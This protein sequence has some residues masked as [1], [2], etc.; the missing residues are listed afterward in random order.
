[1]LA[2]VAAGAVASAA[3]V[4][5]VAAGAVVFAAGVLAVSEGVV[6]GAV[7]AAAAAAQCSEI[8]SSSV[9]AKLLPPAVELSPLALCPMRVTSWFRCGLR[10]TLLVATLK[11]W[12]VLSSTTV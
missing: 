9:T 11:M 5:A 4:L 3:G 2:V 8:M 1:M 12:P 6:T 10:S 7:E